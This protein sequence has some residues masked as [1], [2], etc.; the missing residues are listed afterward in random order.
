M[1][2]AELFAS[3]IF[4]KA[5]KSG[6]TLNSL[7]YPLT[8]IILTPKTV[9]QKAL[10]LRDIRLCRM[11]DTVLSIYIVNLLNLSDFSLSE[12]LLGSV[13]LRKLH[14]STKFC[15]TIDPVIFSFCPGRS[16][17]ICFLCFCG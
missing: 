5:K 4:T 14:S 10:S 17:K 3:N 8:L 16:S 11:V 1:N 13:N 15:D 7:F 9:A 2:F 6:W 12:V